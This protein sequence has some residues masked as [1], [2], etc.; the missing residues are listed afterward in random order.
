MNNEE[1]KLLIRIDERLQSLQKH[2]ANHLSSHAKYTYLVIA[3]AI[4]AF[5]SLILILLRG[6]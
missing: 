2:F 3:S 5:I 4:G 6:G 1:N